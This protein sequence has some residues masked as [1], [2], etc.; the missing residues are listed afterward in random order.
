MLGVM[1]YVH[2]TVEPLLREL[3]RS[4]SSVG[5][6]GPRQS[7]KSTLLKH[8]LPGYRYATLDDPLSRE[9]ALSDPMSFLD[10]LGGKAIIDEIQYAP[11]L[12]SYIKIRIDADRKAKG[13]FI[14]TGSQQ[15]TL[16][17]D[18]ADS[19]AG[20]IALLELL[21]FSISEA[22]KVVDLG[23][24]EKAFVHAALRGLY[25]EPVTDRTIRSGQWYGSYLQ[26]YLERDVRSLQNIGNLRD[27]QR[28][29]QL[30][31]GRCGQQLNLSSFAND[32]GVSVGTVKNWVSILEAG[33]IIYLL[34]PYYRNLGKRV[35]K[36][37]KIYF[38]DIGLAC[39][40]TGIRDRPNLLQGPLA[41]P[42]FEN[43][44]VQ[45]IVKAFFSLGARPPLYYLRTS[46]GLEVDLLIERS[47]MELVPVEIKLNKTPA[48]GMAAPIS[49]L[50]SLFTD[51]PFAD[52]YLV[53]LS[54][55][56]RPLSPGVTIIP[57]PVLLAKVTRMKGSPG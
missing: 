9:Q 8:S 3:V 17:R 41:G 26:T 22:G 33:R 40:L 5:V 38:L 31:A 36:A 27:F 49:R 39:H 7:G 29:V 56:A 21:P 54:D 51:L 13:R 28:F 44:C 52:G 1:E 19:L 47:H 37:P 48:M 24:T 35:T 4:F 18:L 16:I 25:P 15:F 42:L 6:T 57:L 46:N 45:E 20:R 50:R 32:L 10:S 2:R 12:T 34:P 55:D 23:S 43:F 30:M 53:S 14:L 11:G